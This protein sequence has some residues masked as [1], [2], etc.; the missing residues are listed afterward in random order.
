MCPECGLP[1][2]KEFNDAR[3]VETQGTGKKLKIQSFLSATVFCV[4][5][6]LMIAG[7]DSSGIPVVLMI[8]SVVWYF[9]I[10]GLV[11]WKRG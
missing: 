1:L 5:T 8:L 7:T 11:W 9:V 2:I 3:H 4:A 6:I 10:R